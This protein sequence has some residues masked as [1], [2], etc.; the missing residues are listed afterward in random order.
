MLQKRTEQEFK[1]MFAKLTEN[2]EFQFW[3]IK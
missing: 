1:R 2:I 3:W